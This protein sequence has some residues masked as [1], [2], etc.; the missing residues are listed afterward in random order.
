MATDSADSA[1]PCA[2]PAHSQGPCKAAPAD[3]EEDKSQR[4]SAGAFTD[5][6]DTSMQPGGLL[7]IGLTVDGL[8]GL[9]AVVCLPG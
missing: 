6:H 9:H 7:V 5:V 4:S 2:S 1:S 3:D 8:A